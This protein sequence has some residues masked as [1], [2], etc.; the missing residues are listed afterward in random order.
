MDTKELLE[1]I[2]A[3]ADADPVRSHEFWVEG[4]EEWDSVD[5][6]RFCG[7]ERKIDTWELDHIPTCPWLRAQAV[8]ANGV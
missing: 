3:L 4:L 7:A 8:I 1:I 6:C 2:R 5:V